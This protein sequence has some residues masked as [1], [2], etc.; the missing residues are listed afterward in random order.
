ME[1]KPK[2]SLKAIRINNNWSAEET[3]KKYGISLDT[4][5]NYES[6]KTYPDVP[7]IENILNATG[8]KYDN[9]IFLPLNY[10]KTVIKCESD[11]TKN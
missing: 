6:Y 5:R 3:A 11:N 8:M 2:M 9:I 1:E 10:G 7:I 4:L